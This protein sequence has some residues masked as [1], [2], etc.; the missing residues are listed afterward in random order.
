MCISKLS[1]TYHASDEDLALSLIERIQT[2][3]YLSCTAKQ[4]QPLI[5]YSD[6]TR[7]SGKNLRRTQRMANSNCPS[8]DIDFFR[9]ESQLLNA[10]DI[11]V[12]DNNR[13]SSRSPAI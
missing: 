6:P 1:K 3:G 4:H 2:S 8:V 7:Q 10:V 5:Q 11:P 13:I 12:R 9:I